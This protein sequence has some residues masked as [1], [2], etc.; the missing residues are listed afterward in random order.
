MEERLE[1]FVQ[2]GNLA[3]CYEFRVI[4]SLEVVYI[5]SCPSRKDVEWKPD[6]TFHACQRQQTESYRTKPLTETFDKCSLPTAYAHK[7]D[8]MQ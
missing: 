8:A 4:Q 1:D 7:N 2:L 6:A 3:H 5:S